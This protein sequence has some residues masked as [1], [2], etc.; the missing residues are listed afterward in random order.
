MLIIKYQQ[1]DVFPPE[2]TDTGICSW[3]LK[4]NN[5]CLL[6]FVLVVMRLIEPFEAER[7]D[8]VSI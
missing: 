1:L 3:L 4:E 7:S 2:R 6:V 8:T 5:I